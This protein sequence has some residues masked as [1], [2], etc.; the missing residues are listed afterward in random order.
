MSEPRPVIPGRF[1]MITRRVTQRQ[2]LLRPDEETNNAFIYCL[3][4]AARRFDVTVILPQMMSNHHHTIVFDGPGK[5]NEFNHWFHMHLAK[6]QNALRGRWENMWASEPPCIV[7]LIE[8]N[9]VIEKLAYVATNPVK[10]GLVER[11]HHW[12]GPP[13]YSAFMNGKILRATR[14][15]HF[16]R[17]HGP[18]PAELE[19]Q[20]GIPEHLGDGDLI[21]ELLRKRVAELE[22][23]YAAERR[24]K[25]RQILGRRRVL[26]Q[27]WRHQPNSN[28][29]RR[30]LRPRVACRSKWARIEALQRN[31]E[32]LV[33]YREARRDW[34]A[35]KPAVFPLG[36]YWLRRFANVPIAEATP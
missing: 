28:E 20:L 22:T 17:K 27:S 19:L 31:R 12:P 6:C 33:A 34:V 32:F 11:V 14:P 36:T 24:S 13:L 15:R 2:F 26:A 5:I 18:M 4:D 9:D 23:E 3:A 29:P 35:S 21:R 7:E 30:D 16:Y 25:K 8:L 1:Y 10:A